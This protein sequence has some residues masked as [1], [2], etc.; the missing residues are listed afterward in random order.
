MTWRG[1]WSAATA[2]ALNDVVAQGGSSYI[3]VLANTGNSPPNATYWSLVAQI[4]ATGPQGATGATGPAG[5]TGATGPQGP[6]GPPGT[7]VD[8]GTWTALTYATGWSEWDTA[9]FRVETNGSVQTVFCKGRISQAAGSA[10]FAFTFPVGARPATARGTALCGVQ[11]ADGGDNVLYTVTVGTDGVVDI[12][13]MV[14][15]CFVW[16]I[17]TDQ[18]VVYLDGLSFSL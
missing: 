14:K 10:P 12:Y 7:S 5:P 9:R 6:Q 11:V 4:G 16:P 18:Q 8:P 13:P 2:Y 1:N 15:H 17:E 3:C